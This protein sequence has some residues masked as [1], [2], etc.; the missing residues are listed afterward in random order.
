[1]TFLIEMYG[2]FPRQ[3]GIPNRYPINDIND[4]VSFVDKWQGKVRIFS[5]IYNYTANEDIDNE[6]LEISKL[7]FDFDSEN[8]YDNVILFHCYLMEKNL[9]HIMLFSGA[10][11]HVYVFTKNYESL[12]NKKD[13]LFNAQHFLAKELNFKVGDSEQADIDEHIIGDVARIATLLGTWNTK[14]RRWCICVTEGML[15]KGYQFI[16]EYA[17]KQRLSY[18]FYGKEL[19]DMSQFDTNKPQHIE[20]F[21][22]DP[23]IKLTI[24]KDEFL[25]QLPPCIANMLLMKHLGFKRRGY[26]ILYFRDM[27]YLMNETI[28]ILEKYLQPSEF[29][30]CTTK[31]IA[32]GYKEVGE[33]QVQY[34]YK[35]YIRNKINFPGCWK[36]KKYSECPKEG[37]CEEGKKIYKR[38]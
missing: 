1:M 14:R 38:D 25:K 13:A 21:H 4:F 28:S 37:E 7:F 11:F 30:H 8:C 34:F 29:I 15:S 16:N 32:P 10:G 35:T 6:N 26:V 27:G 19:I 12:K 2:K 18:N 36:L 33:E 23:K 24:D 22:A 3:I 31:R 5:S 9:K 20:A 17:K